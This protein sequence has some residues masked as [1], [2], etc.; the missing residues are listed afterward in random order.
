MNTV[1]KTYQEH[2][3]HEP[4]WSTSER[5]GTHV[6]VVEYVRKKKDWSKPPEEHEL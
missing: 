1:R 2:L 4:S 5:D 3:K 6:P